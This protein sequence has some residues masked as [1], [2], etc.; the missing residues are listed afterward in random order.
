MSDVTSFVPYKPQLAFLAKR[1]HQATNTQQYHCRRCR[2]RINNGYSLGT[3]YACTCDIG[4]VQIRSPNLAAAC[5]V[6]TVCTYSHVNKSTISSSNGGLTAQISI[7]R[8]N[9][10]CLVSVSIYKSIIEG[11]SLGTV[12]GCTCEIASVQVRS[13]NIDA[14]C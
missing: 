12:Y 2:N 1:H 3:V 9:T 14:V 10:V 4:S 11:Y 7:N 8:K 5:K 6:D 13:P